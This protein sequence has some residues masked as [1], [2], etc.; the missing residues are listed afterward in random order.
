[1]ATGNREKLIETGLEMLAEKS[2]SQISM[3]EVAERSG[4]T[5]PMIYYYFESKEGFYRAIANHLL[6]MGKAMIVKVFDPRKSLRQALYD[7]VD[8]R[9]DMARNRPKLTRAFL[10][11]MHDPNLT[12]IMEDIR[13]QMQDL[14]GVVRPTIDRA[15]KRGELRPDADPTLVLM[16]VNTASIGY[17]VRIVKEIEDPPLPDARGIVD[18]IF[19]GI[20]GDGEESE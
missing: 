9:L 16:M 1:M 2:Y 10:M 8:M 11:M 13:K 20:A 15:V 3:D 12:L 19:D 6:D 4:V 14:W 17:M 18:V 7:M 5:K